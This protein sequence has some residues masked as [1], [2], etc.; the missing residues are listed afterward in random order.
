MID[1]LLDGEDLFRLPR[2]ADDLDPRVELSAHYHQV[3]RLGQRVD[4]N[5]GAERAFSF[6]ALQKQG[7]RLHKV[8]EQED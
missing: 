1:N 2:L 6:T 3:L 4:G 8:F 5:P 7:F